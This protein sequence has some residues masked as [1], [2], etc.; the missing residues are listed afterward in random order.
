MYLFVTK[1]GRSSSRLC[2]EKSASQV[3]TSSAYSTERYLYYVFA[4][5]VILFV[6]WGLKGETL[7][8]VEKTMYRHLCKHINRY[9]CVYLFRIEPEPFLLLHLRFA[10]PQGSILSP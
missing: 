7:T 2:G 1:A 4:D 9:V 8:A 10:L 3:D 6:G 5:V